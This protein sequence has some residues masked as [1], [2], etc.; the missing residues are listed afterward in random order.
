MFY[1]KLNISYTLGL[2]ITKPSPLNPS[3]LDLSNNM[4]VPQFF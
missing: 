2:K 1:S 3:D 4:K